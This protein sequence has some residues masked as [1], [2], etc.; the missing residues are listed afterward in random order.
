M[1]NEL[2]INQL[3]DEYIQHKLSRKDA[4]AELAQ[5]GVPDAEFELDLHT[6]AV[7]ALKQG[8]VLQQVKNVHQQFLQQSGLGFPAKKIDCLDAPGSSGF[9][10][11]S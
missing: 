10:H 5:Q 7:T 6:A 2:Y 9:P 8:M 11:C 1:N 4:A 3:L